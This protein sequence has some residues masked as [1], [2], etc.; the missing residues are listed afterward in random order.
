MGN[1]PAEKVIETEE[2]LG[3]RPRYMQYNLWAPEADPMVTAA[4]WTITAKPLPHPPQAEYE[5]KEVQ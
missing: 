5:R 3:M 1:Q 2:E 4:K